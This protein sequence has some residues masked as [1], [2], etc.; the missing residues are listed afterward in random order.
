ME[1]QPAKEGWRDKKRKKGREYSR[2]QRQSPAGCIQQALAAY[3]FNAK[4]RKREWG[5]SDGEARVLFRLPCHYCG[6]PP[7]LRNGIDRKDNTQ[8]YIAENCVACCKTCNYAKRGM[9]YA[10]FFAWIDRVAKHNEVK[11]T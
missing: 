1:P 5:L 10:E 9:S 8:G 11:R 4:H 2:E 6:L 7:G 3:R